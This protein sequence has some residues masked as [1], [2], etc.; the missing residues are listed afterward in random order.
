VLPF[1]KISVYPE[2]F[3]NLENEGFKCSVEISSLEEAF[4]NFMYLERDTKTAQF[5]ENAEIAPNSFYLI[6]KINYF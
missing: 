6:S 2:L 5:E 3:E 4:I 1:N